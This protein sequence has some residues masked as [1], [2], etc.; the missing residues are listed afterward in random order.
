MEWLDKPRHKANQKEIEN[1]SNYELRC[2][3]T[4]IFGDWEIQDMIHDEI[5]KRDK[6]KRKLEIKKLFSI[7]F[8]K[9][10]K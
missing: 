9:E 2:Y 5:M 1:A 8:K 4:S 6:E 3:D 7:M 10:I